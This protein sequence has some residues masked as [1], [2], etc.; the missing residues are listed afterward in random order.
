[1]FLLSHQMDVAMVIDLPHPLPPQ[2]SQTYCML[3]SWHICAQQAPFWYSMLHCLTTLLPSVVI[4]IHYYSVCCIKWYTISAS[5][6]CFFIPHPNLQPP[7][8]FIL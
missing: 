3:E 6:H 4:V 5:C 8:P 1:M 7:P 2:L